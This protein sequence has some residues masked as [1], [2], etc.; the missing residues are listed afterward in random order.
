MKHLVCS[1][2]TRNSLIIVLQGEHKFPFQAHA[3][4]SQLCNDSETVVEKQKRIFL[5]ERTQLLNLKKREGKPGNRFPRQ[6]NIILRRK[7]NP[8]TCS[9]SR[10]LP[11]VSFT[12]NTQTRVPTAA[13]IRPSLPCSCTSRF[14]AYQLISLSSP[15]LS[16]SPS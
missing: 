12:T 11:T 13:P 10:S 15:S 3:N 4:F 6:Q 14:Y 7:C 16:P 8:T 1:L 5:V 2:C 9:H